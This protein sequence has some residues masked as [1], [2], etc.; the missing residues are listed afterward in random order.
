MTGD[1]E[2]K[3]GLVAVDKA[4]YVMNS[5]HNLTQK[6]VRTCGF[7]VKTLP[8]LSSWSFTFFSCRMGNTGGHQDS[9]SPHTTQRWAGGKGSVGGSLRIAIRASSCSALPGLP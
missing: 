7:G 6:K 2:A 8:G 5:K 9:G 3:V 1:A 4:V